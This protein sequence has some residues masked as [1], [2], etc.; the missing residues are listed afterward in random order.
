MLRNFYCRFLSLVKCL[1]TIFQSSL[2]EAGLTS[3]NSFTT[4]LCEKPSRAGVPVVATIGS[5]FALTQH[6]PQT[7]WQSQR[8][9]EKK[10]SS[11]DLENITTFVSNL[12][13]DSRQLLH[14]HVE[15]LRGQSLL[16]HLE[17][18]LWLAAH[19]HGISQVLD[20]TLDLTLT[21]QFFSEL[22]LKSRRMSPFLTHQKGKFTS[23]MKNLWTAS[24]SLR[25]GI[26]GLIFILSFIMR[27]PA[28]I[29]GNTLVK[30]YAHI[31]I[32]Q[33]RHSHAY[34]ALKMM[35]DE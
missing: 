2:T 16:K 6:H 28:Q 35:S 32:V 30:Q 7:Q 22:H 11:H 26:L 33:S 19:R 12:V 21:E 18:L 23:C 34:F 31:F 27:R 20:S 17:E 13:H 8:F 3:G 10:N 24:W 4:L 1:C 15:D 9:P 5:H 14:E 25:F 29:V